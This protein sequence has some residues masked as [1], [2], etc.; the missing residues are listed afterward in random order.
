MA[1]MKR[2]SQE[3][4]KPTGSNPLI[5]DQI[6]RSSDTIVPTVKVARMITRIH[7]ACSPVLR[8]EV[9]FCL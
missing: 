8:A 4:R 9:W 1:V 2:S 6:T 5:S 3:S 7:M